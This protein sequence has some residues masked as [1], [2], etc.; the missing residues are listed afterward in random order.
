MQA[1][2]NALSR[3]EQLHG[4]HDQSIYFVGV[5]V[6][7]RL[8]EIVAEFERLPVPLLVREL[9]GLEERVGVVLT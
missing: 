6:R 3:S 4:Y 9:V 5:A 2:K 1:I 7:V 8:I